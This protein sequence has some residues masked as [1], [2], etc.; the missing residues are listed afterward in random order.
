MGAGHTRTTRTLTGCPAA[1]ACHLASPGTGGSAPRRSLPREGGRRQ[2]QRGSTTRSPPSR[3]RPACLRAG[4]RVPRP[5]SRAPGQPSPQLPRDG[6][7]ARVGL[8]GPG[9]LPHWASPWLWGGGGLLSPPRS[10]PSDLGELSVQGK[11]EPPP[12]RVQ[13]ARAAPCPCPRVPR[14]RRT[15]PGLVDCGSRPDP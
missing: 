4:T 3:M 10:A 13:G 9:E 2:G 6:A 15:S 11:R 5:H 14:E 8:R 7:Q 1:P 12:T